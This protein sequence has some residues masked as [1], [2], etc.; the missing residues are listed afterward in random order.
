MNNRHSSNDIYT[1][2]LYRLNE[3]RIALNNNHL[4]QPIY[5]YGLSNAINATKSTI[6]DVGGVYNGYPS[7]AV[8]ADIYSSDANDTLLGSH[9]RKITVV[10]LDANWLDQS[11]TVSLLG[12][13]HVQTTKTWRR[14]FRAYVTEGGTP[15]T[16]NIG[17]ITI[18]QLGVSAV[19]FAQIKAT[20]GQTHMAVYTVPAN[21]KC[22][23]LNVDAN[24]GEG[25][26]A[27]I[28]L[29]TRENITGNEVFLKKASRFIYE[30]SFTRKYEIPRLIQ[31]KTDIKMSGIS[32]AVGVS[33]SAT[34]EMLNV[35]LTFE[36]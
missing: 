32:S 29:E 14:I 12:T 34:F 28:S 3:F 9:A 18:E 4:L 16:P 11:E 17:D 33:V 36:T 8:V 20:Y 35:D 22:L 21:F 19:Q 7:S 5:K 6:W 1:S 27:E 26:E 23:L 10:G 15:N 25:K 30:N 2:K 31:P 13:T 24:C